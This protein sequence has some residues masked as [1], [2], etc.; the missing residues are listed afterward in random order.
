MVRKDYEEDGNVVGKV[1]KNECDVM[2]SGNRRKKE[3]KLAKR[4][5]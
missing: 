4:I 2:S 5:L 3:K 1:T